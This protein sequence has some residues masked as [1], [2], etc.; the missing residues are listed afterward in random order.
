MG[1]TASKLKKRRSYRTYILESHISSFFT[2][3]TRDMF[4]LDKNKPGC[5]SFCKDIIYLVVY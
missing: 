3:T 4:I 5:N 2:N 1:K